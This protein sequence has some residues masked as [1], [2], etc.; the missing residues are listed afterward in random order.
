MNKTQRQYLHGSADWSCFG[1]EFSDDVTAADPL[2]ALSY[3]SDRYLHDDSKV[4]RGW[5]MPHTY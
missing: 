3:Y 2:N 1:S 5:R 4:A